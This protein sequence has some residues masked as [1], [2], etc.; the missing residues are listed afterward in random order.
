LRN[1]SVRG[2]KERSVFSEYP[3]PSFFFL[4]PPSLLQSL[5]K[6]KDTRGFLCYKDFLR[7]TGA[8]RI[9]PFRIH[10]PILKNIPVSESK[11]AFAFANYYNWWERGLEVNYRWVLLW[12]QIKQLTTSSIGCGEI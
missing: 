3:A 11:Q 9:P 5:Y 6:G 2:G 12:L 8:C 10:F 7:R 1:K 4:H